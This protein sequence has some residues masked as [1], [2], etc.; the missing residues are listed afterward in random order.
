[1]VTDFLKFSMPHTDISIIH[2]AR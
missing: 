2:T 1:V